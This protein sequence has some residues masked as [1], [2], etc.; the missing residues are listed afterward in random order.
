MPVNTEHKKTALLHYWL[1]HM[2]GGEMVFAEFC[3]RFPGAEIFTHAAIK[4]NLS[5]AITAHPIHE[6]LI[7]KMP[8]GRECCQ[9]YLPL[10]PFALKQWNFDGYDLLLSSESGPIKGIRKPSGCRH[11]CYCHTPMRY[12]W[13]MYDEYYDSASLFPRLGMSLFKKQ[14]RSYDRRSADS[15]D[16]F[17]ANSHFVAERIKRI[18]QRESTVLYPPVDVEYFQ[19]APSSER[20][21]Y[22]Y[23]GALVCYK[24]PD[25]AVKAF[26]KHPDQQLIVV[27]NGPMKRE[28]HKLAT[29]NVTFIHDADKEQIRTLYASA[30][31]LIFPGIEDFGIVPVEAQAAGCPVIAMNRGGTLETVLDHRSGILIKKQD[32]E[33]ILN[34]IEELS[35]L[36]LPETEVR[37]HTAQ[38]TTQEFH[39]KLDTVLN[40]NSW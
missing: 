36:H 24:R 32:V 14:L 18:Y 12:L 19:S 27:G 29:P 9:S 40:D 4:E 38:F 6:S 10:M 37:A 20:T 2:R 25:L 34:G 11:I 16:T 28:L 33:S 31:A 22:L 15:V 23:V 35:G 5:D 3:K 17:L 30:K 1:Q 8:F 26:A 21:H 39:K 13:D 7:A